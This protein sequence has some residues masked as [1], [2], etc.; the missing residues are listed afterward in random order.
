MDYGTYYSVI[1]YL[2]MPAWLLLAF[3]PQHAV[4]Q[5]LVH[6]G[7]YPVIF[8]LFYLVLWVRALAFGESAEGGG[9]ATLDTI[10]VAFSHPNVSL[11][12]WAH[13][14]VFDL[15]VGAWIGRDSAARGVNHFFV[16]PCLIFAFLAGPIGLLLYLVLRQVTGKGS[17]MALGNNEVGNG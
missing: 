15:F 10:M 8:G 16:V 3:L 17:V 13:Y 14:L 1:N 4:T 5:K 7:I 12:G 2:V 11:M 6:S 9:F